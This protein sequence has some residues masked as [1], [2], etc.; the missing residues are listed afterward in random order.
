VY[1]MRNIII[2]LMIHMLF[3]VGCE[4]QYDANISISNIK[5]KEPIANNEIAFKEVP[6]DS[7]KGITSEEALKLCQNNIGE[8]DDEKFIF[9]MAEIHTGRRIGYRCDGAMECSAEQYYIIRMLWTGDNDTIWSTIG[10]L[11]ASADGNEIYEI[12]SHA[13]TYSLGK[14]IWKSETQG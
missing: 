3:L 6:V 4:K 11:G 14:L 8:I 2:V 5:M 12:H 13:G 7:V 1:I 9:Q 10:F